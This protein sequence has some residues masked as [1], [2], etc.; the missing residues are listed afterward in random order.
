MKSPQV[1]WNEILATTPAPQQGVLWWLGQH[2][3]ALRLGEAVVLLDAYLAPNPERLIPP[4]LDPTACSGVDLILGTHDHADHIDREVWPALAQASPQARF[5]VPALV[6]ERVIA[7]LGL[8]PERVLGVDEQQPL[9]ACGLSVSGVA[10]AHEF[11]EQ[12]AETGLYPHLGYVI[13][14]AGLCL[15]H[16]GDCCVYEGL[17]TKLRQWRFDVAC[18]PIN[19][20][21]AQRLAAG[22][23]GNMTYQ[24]AVDLA[25]ALQPGLTIP[26]HWDMFASNSEDPQLF[27][28]YARVKYPGLE[29]HLPEYGERVIFPA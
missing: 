5:V 14:G 15:Y 22:C 16:A 25:G 3:F 20:R 1:L 10:A 11:L 28:D 18:L 8:A 12:D 27:A 13:E 24:E 17:L 23:I 19:G 9:E 29:V 6:R 21:D 4:L 7:D 2:G 26:T